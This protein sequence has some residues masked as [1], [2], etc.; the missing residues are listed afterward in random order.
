M[1]EC[2]LEEVRARIQANHV[3]FWVENSVENVAERLN[4]SYDVAQR[5]ILKWISELTDG[6]FYKPSPSPPPP[7]DVY[8][9]KKMHAR[10]EGGRVRFDEVEWYIKVKFLGDQL[11]IC[12]C[13]P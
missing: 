13:H 10:I 2:P 3:I 6:D 7:A 4:V 11:V 12:S 9:V 1:P 5:E 8:L